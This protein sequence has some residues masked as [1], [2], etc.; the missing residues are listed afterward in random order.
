MQ[1]PSRAGVAIQSLDRHLGRSIIARVARPGEN[2]ETCVRSG[3]SF[4]GDGVAGQVLE[5]R[6]VFGLVLGGMSYQDVSRVAVGP[7][8]DFHTVGDF[9]CFVH[10]RLAGRAVAGGDVAGF[11]GHYERGAS[12]FIV[13]VPDQNW[14]R[15]FFVDG[16]RGFCQWARQELDP[17]KAGGEGGGG[18][19][20][21]GRAIPSA[22]RWAWCPAGTPGVRG[23]PSM[24]PPADCQLRRRSCQRDVWCPAGT[25]VRSAI[26]PTSGDTEN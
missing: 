9:V 26:P 14:V 19:L 16:P 8:F 7:A 4:N 10:D 17:S 18:G 2:N 3:L 1:S 25:P 11:V 12:R 22:Y 23:S 13:P 20:L 15:L 21:T 5:G 6:D 24:A